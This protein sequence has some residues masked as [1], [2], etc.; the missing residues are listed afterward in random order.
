MRESIE[1]GQFLILET[2]LNVS[3]SHKK[4]LFDYFVRGEK[5]SVITET[6]GITKPVVYRLKQHFEN[7]RFAFRCAEKRKNILMLDQLL[8]RK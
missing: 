1:K 8:L 4:V 5:V 2:L 6:Y 3:E 7:T